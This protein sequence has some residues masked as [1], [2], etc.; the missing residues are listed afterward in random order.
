MSDLELQEIKEEVV[1]EK[2]LTFWH[3]YKAHIVA[4]LIAVAIVI[5]VVLGISSYRQGQREEAASMLLELLD[6]AVAGQLD[7]DEMTALQGKM[8][9]FPAL[10]TMTKANYEKVRGK[11]EYVK[12][13]RDLMEKGSDPL[14]REVAVVRLGLHLL[15]EDEFPEDVKEALT[16]VSKSASPFAVMAREVLAH[17]A[18]QQDDPKA[19]EMF[20]ELRNDAFATHQQ[21]QRALVFLA[22][23]S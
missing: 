21:K 4:G 11:D 15:S 9:P 6:S 22:K 13:L 2:I 17:W 1:V 5:A 18:L 20:E 3:E 10:T 8:N 23:I 16:K 12:T 19:K 7:E 14:F